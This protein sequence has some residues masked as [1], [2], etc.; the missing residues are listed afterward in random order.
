MKFDIRNYELLH[1]NKKSLT[2]ISKSTEEVLFIGK[3]TYNNLRRYDN[4]VKLVKVPN[5]HYPYQILTW[6]KIDK[7]G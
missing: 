3:W 1:I 2:L 7:K 4:R 6:I 5:P